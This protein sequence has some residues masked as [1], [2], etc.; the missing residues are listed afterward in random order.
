MI[1]FDKISEFFSEFYDFKLSDESIYCDFH[2]HTSRTLRDGGAPYHLQFLKDKKHLVS[3]TDHNEIKGA[4]AAMDAGINNVPGIELACNDGF[5]ILV[6]FKKIQELEDF[7]IQEVECRKHF[8]RIGRTDKDIE[9]YLD[10]L[11]GRDSYISIPHINGLAGQNYLQNKP[12]IKR[13]LSRIDAIE[14]YNHGLPKNRNITAQIIRRTY[15]L[16]ATFGSDAYISREIESFYR[17]L[18]LELKRHHKWVENLYKL[19]SVSGLAYG[20][21]VHLRK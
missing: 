6:Y 21:L 9:Y 4:I 19:P 7:Y 20:Q 3:I 15:D 1:E 8:C 12:Y 5:E 13:V 17:L 18:N 16:E 11:V 2:F 14:T 10:A